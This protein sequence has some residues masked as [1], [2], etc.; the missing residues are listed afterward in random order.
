MDNRNKIEVK[1]AIGILIIVVVAL[2]MWLVG[3][4]YI[5]W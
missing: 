5:P 1:P 2:A 4:G 3:K